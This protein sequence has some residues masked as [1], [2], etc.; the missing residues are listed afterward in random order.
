L[1]KACK[2]EKTTLTGAFVAAASLEVLEKGPE[3]A[4][5]WLG[6]EGSTPW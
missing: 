3:Y 2:R 6:S 1:L 4:R 5:P